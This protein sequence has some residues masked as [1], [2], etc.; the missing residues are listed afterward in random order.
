MEGKCRDRRDGTG[1][2]SSF[3]AR[4]QPRQHILERQLARLRRLYIS[5]ADESSL[6]SIGL[7]I[8]SFEFWRLLTADI[9][10][11]LAFSNTVLRKSGRLVSG[12]DLIWEPLI[13]GRLSPFQLLNYG[14]LRVTVKF[15]PR[16]IG[17]APEMIYSLCNFVITPIIT[18][19]ITRDFSRVLV[20]AISKEKLFFSC[21]LVRPYAVSQI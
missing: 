21:I 1:S 14:H 4:T 9:V 11:S 17:N 18:P 16:S 13:I 6:L 8:V 5:I 7:W 20:R 2:R 3:C 10:E 15:K 19:T 12:R